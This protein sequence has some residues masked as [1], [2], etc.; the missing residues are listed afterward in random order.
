MTK[1]VAY[2]DTLNE[3]CSV[4]LKLEN[5]KVLQQVKLGMG[6]EEEPALDDP[7]AFNYTQKSLPEIEEEFKMF[8]S[9]PMKKRDIDENEWT[10]ALQKFQKQIDLEKK[11]AAARR[12]GA[13]LHSMRSRQAKENTDSLRS[14]AEKLDKAHYVGSEKIPAEPMENA[15]DVSEKYVEISD[16]GKSKKVLIKKLSQ[17]QEKDVARMVMAKKIMKSK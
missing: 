12:K 15:R 13:E 4:Y 11:I 16:D 1:Y 5:D 6:L 7:L 3:G 9:Y 2:D 14:K 17:R 8:S 10:S